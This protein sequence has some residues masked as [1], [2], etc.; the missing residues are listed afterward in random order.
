MNKHL[1]DKEQRQY[2][3]YNSETQSTYA[4]DLSQ[5]FRFSY[6]KVCNIL[7]NI[8]HLATIGNLLYLVCV[9]FNIYQRHPLVQ[10]VVVFNHTMNCFRDILKYQVEIKFILFSC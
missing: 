9:E 3:M 2:M 7:L 4:W 8:F 1:R 5:Q 10:L 6:L